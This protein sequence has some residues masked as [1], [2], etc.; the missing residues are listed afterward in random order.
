MRMTAQTTN[1]M[2]GDPSNAGSY[3]ARMSDEPYCNP[4]NPNGDDPK[5]RP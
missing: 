5:H 4:D 3:M 1:A 2:K